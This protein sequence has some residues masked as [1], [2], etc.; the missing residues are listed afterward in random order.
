MGSSGSTPCRQ[1]GD[2]CPLLALPAAS[3]KMGQIFGLRRMAALGFTFPQQLQVQ[4]SH[5]DQHNLKSEE[6]L[7]SLISFLIKRA[8]YYRCRK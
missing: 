6:Q 2:G 4:S 7:D 1:E 5:L 3:T 8:N